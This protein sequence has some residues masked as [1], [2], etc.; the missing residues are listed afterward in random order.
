MQKNKAI[1]NV[2][3]TTAIDL[4]AQLAQHVE[5]FEKTR[6]STGKQIKAG[7]PDK[8]PTVWTRQNKGVQGRNQKDAQQQLTQ[9]EGSILA[10]SREQL[11]R[12]A[13]IYEAMQ[14]G[15]YQH[16]EY[17][18]EDQGPLIDFDRKYMQEVIL[19]IKT[20]ESLLIHVY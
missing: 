6:S 14:S 2:S 1:Q 13:L 4:R 8:K 12:K 17:E 20:L 10:K 19:I 3:A 11:E 15:K 7:K 16:D 18:N 5:Q 9:V